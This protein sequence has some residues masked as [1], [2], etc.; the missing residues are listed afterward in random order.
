MKR[1]SGAVLLSFDFELLL[2]ILT[3]SGQHLV[4]TIAEDSSSGNVLFTFLAGAAS[5]NFRLGLLRGLQEEKAAAMETPD[6]SEREVLSAIARVQRQ[7]VLALVD[8]LFAGRITARR[9]I[10]FCKNTTLLSNTEPPAVEDLVVTP[11]GEEMMDEAGI[12]GLVRCDITFLK[13]TLH[14][15]EGATTSERPVLRPEW[16]R[17]YMLIANK[18]KRRAVSANIIALTG[19]GAGH[20]RLGLMKKAYDYVEREVA[21]MQK[22]EEA[23]AQA[24]SAGMVLQ[25]LIPEGGGAA[26]GHR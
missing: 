7:I 14:A 17:L 13:T 24:K 2:D 18:K 20:G 21:T 3:K 10:S 1:S 19:Q 22:P 4:N 8:K 11:Q 12:V 9:I 6:L 15:L 16:K 26:G 5:K 25:K 23:T